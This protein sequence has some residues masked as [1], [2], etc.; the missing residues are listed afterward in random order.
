M[1]RM[2]PTGQTMLNIDPLF[3]FP[4]TV[5]L[6]TC[7][8]FYCTY[9]Y[10][11]TRPQRLSLAL[12][13]L[14]IIALLFIVSLRPNS[15]LYHKTTQ[16]D[17]L[18]F[19]TDISDSMTI[20][21]MPQQL[22]RSE[23]TLQLKERY[24]VE[25]ERLKNQ[26]DLE[27]LYFGKELKTGT[28]ISTKATGMGQALIE[29]AKSSSFSNI[30]GI[31]LFSD[32][33]SNHGLSINNAISTISKGEIPI[34]AI[35]IGQDSYSDSFID[36]V[37]QDLSCPPVLKRKTFLHV[38]TEGMIKGL[39][40]KTYELEFFINDKLIKAISL[41]QKEFQQSVILSTDDLE[42]GLQKL[43]VNINTGVHEISPLNN[44][45]DRYFQVTDNG[46]SVLLIAT[47]PSAD[48]KFLSRFLNSRTDIEPTIKGPFYYRTPE[49]SDYLNKIDVSSFDLIIFQNPDIALLPHNFLTQCDTLLKTRRQGIVFQGPQILNKF[50]DYKF[51]KAYLPAETAKAYNPEKPSTLKVTAQGKL[52]YITRELPTTPLEIDGLSCPTRQVGLAQTLLKAGDTPLLITSSYQRCKTAWINSNALWQLTA[53]EAGRAFYHS[54]WEKLIYSLTVRETK[55]KSQLAIYTGKYRFELGEEITVTA[56]LINPQNIPIK[57]ATIILNRKN[58]TQSFA[59]QNFNVNL[60]DYKIKISPKKEGLY[61][62]HAETRQDGK[63]LKSKTINIFIE[64]PKI[65]FKTTLANKELMAKAASLTQGKLIKP[66]EFPLLLQE[67]EENA[68]V[69]SIRS[70]KAKESLWDNIY[71]YLIFL[72]LCTLEWQRRRI[73]RLP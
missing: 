47:S 41:P 73:V 38:D 32:G 40:A 64:E 46:L 25:I 11:K 35:P 63:L 24:K 2:Y 21:D 44:K 72:I 70:L 43:T 33:Q 28:S 61:T 20:K 50:T 45:L 62:L 7:L 59:P 34:H 4:L 30:K 55:Q 26:Y 31:V 5:A 53:T 9:S 51:L 69:H 67:L 6:F 12:I 10:R 8:A 27:E 15:E 56:N 60:E 68:K 22:S 17:K 54:L 23:Y 57:N 37:L 36:G 48:F 49:G 13:R 71:I 3:P 14:S 39:H 52:H 29:T 18:Y 16:K 65:E 19:L 66:E 42:L 58:T 1:K